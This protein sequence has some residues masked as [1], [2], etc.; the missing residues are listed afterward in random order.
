MPTAFSGA[1]KDS[2]SICLPPGAST[3][4]RKKGP[5]PK[6]LKSNSII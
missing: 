5:V 3:I 2:S 6:D 4:K 1:T